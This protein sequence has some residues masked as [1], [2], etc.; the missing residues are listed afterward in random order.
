MDHRVIFGMNIFLLMKC[1]SIW[2]HINKEITLYLSNFF[3]L[4]IPPI[5]LAESLSYT[6]LI[7]A[8]FICAIELK[9]L[10]LF[11]CTYRL[12]ALSVMLQWMGILL[13]GIAWAKYGLTGLGPHTT[14]G[15]LFMGGSEVTYLMLLLL[16]AKGYTI[17]R[18]RLSSSSVIKLTIFVN[19]Y[20]V[21]YISLFIFQSQ[22]E[23]CCCCLNGNL[24]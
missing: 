19:I 20:I 13:Q 9:S 16:M 2:C 7:I 6:F 15:G 12:Y 3:Y 11:H 24:I 14:L 21:V 4:D 23:L 22:V 1:V 8:V 5:L 18:A 17:T 10:H